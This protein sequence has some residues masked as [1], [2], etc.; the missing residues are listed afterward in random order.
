MDINCPYCNTE[1]DIDHEDG[2][3]YEE[4]EIHNQQCRNCD[5][6]FTYTT[7]V[8]YYYEPEKSICL[9]GGE[10]E[11]KPTFAYP[12]KFSLMRCQDCGETR[13]LTDQEK[14]KYVNPDD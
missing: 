14:L 7:S 6:F 12:S 2:Y 1:L 9:N 5:K 10:H 11:Y 4:D 3:G 8:I 13:E